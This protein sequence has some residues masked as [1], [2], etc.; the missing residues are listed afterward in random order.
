MQFRTTE[1]LLLL[2]AMALPASG[3]AQTTPRSTGNYANGG[4]RNQTANR[5]RRAPPFQS[6]EHHSSAGREER[7]LGSQRHPLP[8]VRIDRGLARW[9]LR[10][11]ISGTG[12]NTVDGK[13]DARGPGS[14]G[15]GW[16]GKASAAALYRV[17]LFSR[18]NTQSE[19]ASPLLMSACTRPSIMKVGDT[20]IP[21]WRAYLQCHLISR[22]RSRIAKASESLAPL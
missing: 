3:V 21:F 8:G 11:I 13:T 5:H 14:G 2:G 17:Q 7:R 20:W 16:R 9:R 18:R 12:A 15:G 22:S 4:R 19:I 1:L 10:T 6:A